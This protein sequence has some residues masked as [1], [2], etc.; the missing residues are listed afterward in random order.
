MMLDILE[1]RIFEAL[2]PKTNNIESMT[3]DLPLPFGPT[4]ELKDCKC[5][6]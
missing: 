4:I 2:Y 3:F 6:D 1:E 5:E